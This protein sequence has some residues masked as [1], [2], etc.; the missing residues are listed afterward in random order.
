MP[1]SIARC[2][3]IEGL[4]YFSDFS[5]KTPSKSRS[6]SEHSAL[7]FSDN[8]DRSADVDSF[9][10]FLSFRQH[11]SGTH[12]TYVQPNAGNAKKCDEEIKR[13]GAG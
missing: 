9:S 3:V 6:I 13:T 1:A 12:L 10:Q 8:L 5:D 4:F 11:R 2:T 7:S